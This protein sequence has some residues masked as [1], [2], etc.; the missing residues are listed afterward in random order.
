MVEL[1]IKIDDNLAERLKR[2][3]GESTWDDTVRELLY[4]HDPEDFY[5][6]QI[7]DLITIIKQRLMAKGNNETW[8]VLILSHIQRLLATALKGDRKAVYIT[9]LELEKIVQ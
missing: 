8:R 7:N 1:R 5:L 9:L 2:F 6:E 4:L 3:K